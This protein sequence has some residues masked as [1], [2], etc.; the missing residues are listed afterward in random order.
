MLYQMNSTFKY[1]RSAFLDNIEMFTSENEKDYF[2]FHLHDYYCVS[3]ITK[4]TE[5]LETQTSTYYATTGTISVTQANEAHKNYSVD[6]SGY[7]Y[8]TIYV[9][10]D[11]LKYYNDGIPVKG[12]ERVIENE[13]TV[14]L[15]SNL[16]SNSLTDLTT[17]ETAIKSLTQYSKPIQQERIYSFDLIDELIANAGFNKLTIDNVARQFCMSKYHFIRRFKKSKGITPQAYI[18]LRRLEK[19]KKMLFKGDD[20]K[21]IAFMNGFYDATHLNTAFKRFFGISAFMLKN[22]NIIHRDQLK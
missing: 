20:I 8:Q 4:G 19:A 9:T 17:I 14:N 16:F 10:P 12:L 7:S 1:L 18:M 6:Q 2:P 15:I 21:T 11:L 13:R 22:S 5:A 3:L